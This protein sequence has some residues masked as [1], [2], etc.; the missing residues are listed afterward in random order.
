MWFQLPETRTWINLAQAIKIAVVGDR[1]HIV[2][3]RGEVEEVAMQHLQVVLDII[4]EED[5]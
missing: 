3:G 4:G 2:F 5:V 1:F